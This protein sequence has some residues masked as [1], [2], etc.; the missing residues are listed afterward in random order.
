MLAEA[1]Y[2]RLLDMTK[3]GYL[4][5]VAFESGRRYNMLQVFA[6][7]GEEVNALTGAPDPTRK[8]V[9]LEN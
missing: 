2:N 7:L 8:T 4:M 3:E 9:V 5:A 6:L 1:T